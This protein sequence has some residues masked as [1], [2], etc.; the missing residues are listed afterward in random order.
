MIGL[1]T[2]K[3][4]DIEALSRWLQRFQ[5]CEGQAEPPVI[6][7]SISPFLPKPHTPF[8]REKMEDTDSLWNKGSHIKAALR[9]LRNVMVSYR[10]PQ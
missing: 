3:D 6:H 5:G 2:E 8:C 7:V 4:E 10:N 9:N 1:P